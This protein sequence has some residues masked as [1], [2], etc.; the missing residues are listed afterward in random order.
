MSLIHLLTT[1]IR[2]TFLSEVGKN[3]K[4]QRA[5]KGMLL[6]FKLAPRGEEEGYRY[7]DVLLY[8]PAN[9]VGVYRR[10]RWDVIPEADLDEDGPKPGK[11]YVKGESPWE[12]LSCHDSGWTEGVERVLRDGR[13]STW[14]WADWYRVVDT[15]QYKLPER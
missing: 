13:I 14:E 2:T 3:Q 15:T 12:L 9:Y 10:E 8:A 7:L 6:S 5:V 11:D 1:V 4:S